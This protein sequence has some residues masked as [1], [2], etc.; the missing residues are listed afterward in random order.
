MLNISN[1]T[2]IFVYCP[3]NHV[4]GGAE[5][6]H[7]LVDKLNNYALNAYIVYSNIDAKIPLE[8]S[9]YNIKTTDQIIDNEHNIVVIYEGILQKAFCI[10]KA[11]IVLWWLS[12]DNFYYCST[13]FLSLRDYFTWKPSYGFYMLLRRV[14]ILAIKQRNIFNTKSLQDIKKLDA[15]NCYQSEYAQNFLLNNGFVR[16]A[17]LTDYIN[18]DFSSS[19]STSKRENIVLYNPKK[20]YQFTKQIIKATPDITWKPLIGMSRSE[21]INTFQ[22]SKL[23]LDFG[24]HPGKDRIPRE[25]AIN[26]CCVITGL[27]GSARFFEDVAIPNYFKIDE[28]HTPISSIVAR[29]ND[30]FLNFEK[31]TIDFD[32]YRSKIKREETEFDYQIRNIFNL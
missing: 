11:Q 22:S 3:A 20:G 10:E 7:Q 17:P 24:Y 14:A 2:K 31:Y 19:N 32:Y 25:A 4:T 8:Y 1:H 23:Y 18:S 9:A 16:L 26:G 21:L 27:Q 13:N 30:I 12:V 15:V 29:I 5:L 6:L 28:Q